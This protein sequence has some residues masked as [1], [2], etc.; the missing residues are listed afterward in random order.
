MQRRHGASAKS[1]HAFRGRRRIESVLLFAWP[2]AS[3]YSQ[4]ADDQFNVL[5]S[6]RLAQ[7][8]PPFPGQCT[9]ADYRR[10]QRSRPS[11]PRCTC[12]AR[13]SQGTKTI[14]P[15]PSQASALCVEPCGHCGHPCPL[16]KGHVWTLW[17]RLMDVVDYCLDT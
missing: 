2:C 13:N 14:L 17:K 16:P 8:Q 1:R 4:R 15:Q 9:T 12:T 3:I 5:N 10:A 11:S 7:K 6:L